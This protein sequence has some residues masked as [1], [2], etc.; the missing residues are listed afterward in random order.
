MDCNA[1]GGEFRD[2]TSIPVS[3]ILEKKYF[4]VKKK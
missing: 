3:C 1:H 2:V 4:E